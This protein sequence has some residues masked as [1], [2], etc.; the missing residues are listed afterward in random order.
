MKNKLIMK[1]SNNS[2]NVFRVHN[3]QILIFL[4]G[5]TLVNC[6]IVV[7][8]LKN[9]MKSKFYLI[10]SLCFIASFGFSQNYPTLE[11]GQKC[12][13]IDFNFTSVD[14][15][16]YQLKDHFGLNGLLVVFTSNTCPFVVKWEDRYKM[17]EKWCRDNN[18]EM[19][20]VNSNSKLR[21][22]VDSFEAMQ[23][24]SAKMDYKFP[25][26]IDKGSLLANSF[27]AK[28][29]PHIFL[30]NNKKVLVYKGAIDDN[31]NSAKDVRSFYLKDAITFLCD[32]VEIKNSKTKAVGCSIKRAL[33]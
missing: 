20:Y 6:N 22:D 11:I 27:G 29:T 24:H 1:N 9:K 4:N 10:L 30:F 28:T 17:A 13:S 25:Y 23:K 32:G 7:N 31:Y 18:I 16:Q 3:K 15:E 2:N 5:S 8:L 14:S 21:D 19:V 26:I 12:P 33:N